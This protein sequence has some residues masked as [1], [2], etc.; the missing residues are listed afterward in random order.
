MYQCLSV[1]QLQAHTV[2][3]STSSLLVFWVNR[4]RQRKKK[5]FF[6]KIDEINTLPLG[7]VG[8]VK[9][10]SLLLVTYGTIQHS[11]AVTGSALTPQSHPYD[12]K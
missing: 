10:S 2:G 3:G 6:E 5:L 7:R 1:Y 11:G 4:Y 9:P 8:V 12:I